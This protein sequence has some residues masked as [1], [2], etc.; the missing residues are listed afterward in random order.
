M[1][2]EYVFWFDDIQR[3]I[4]KGFALVILEWELYAWLVRPVRK[5][6]D[7]ETTEG[8]SHKRDGGL[9]LVPRH[10]GLLCPTTAL[11]GDL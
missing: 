3:I 2:I 4:L 10:F 1:S 5:Q 7:D 9:D 6:A 8:N 11:R